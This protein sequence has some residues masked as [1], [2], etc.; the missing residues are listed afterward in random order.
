MRELLS[1]QRRTLPNRQARRQIDYREVLN[2]QD[3]AVFARLRTLRKNWPTARGFRPTPCSP[4]NNWP[5]WSSAHADAAVWRREQLRRHPLRH[6][7]CD[8]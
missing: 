2:E 4:T 8:L 5:S 3:F 6:G 7:L 1:S